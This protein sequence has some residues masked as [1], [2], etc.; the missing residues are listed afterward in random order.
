MANIVAEETSSITIPPPMRTSVVVTLAVWKALFLR[1]AVARLAAQ[2]GAWLWILLEPVSHVLVL[3]ALFGFIFQRI[4]A[5]IDGAMF[6]MTGFLGYFVFRHVMSQGMEAVNANT[7]LFAYRQVKPVDTV[8]VR[9]ALEGFLSLLTAILLLAG[10]A[11]LGYEIVPH[12]P[13]Q[14]LTAFFFLWLAGVGMALIMSVAATLI[15]EVGKLSKM[16]LQPLYLLSG[17]LHPAMTIPQPYRGWLL[18]NPILHGIELLRAGFFSQF[19]PAPGVSLLY[20]GFF[21]IATTFLGLV[22]HL[23]FALKLVSK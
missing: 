3:M 23:R 7:A 11:L 6:I 14:V 21:G 1:E 20:L 8:L 16:L 10:S 4:I 18:V 22:L 2:R 19:H 12:N 9:A 15:P 13:L 5:G 17:V